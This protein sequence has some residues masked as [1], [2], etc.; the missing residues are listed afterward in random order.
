MMAQHVACPLRENARFATG[1]E[2]GWP[3]VTAAQPRKC[4]IDIPTGN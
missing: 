1:S 3:L 4:F 2:G